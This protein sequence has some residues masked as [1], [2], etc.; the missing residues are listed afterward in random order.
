MKKFFFAF[1]K[2]VINLQGNDFHSFLDELKTDSYKLRDFEIFGNNKLMFLEI[3]VYKK[4]IK[5]MD[6]RR[7]INLISTSS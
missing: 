4:D 2:N 5:I 6:A 7:E 1:S 3:L